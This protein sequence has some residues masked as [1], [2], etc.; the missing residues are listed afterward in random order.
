MVALYH[1][2]YSLN[3]CSTNDQGKGKKEEN[4]HGTSLNLVC[5]GLLAIGHGPVFGIIVLFLTDLFGVHR[6]PPG[7]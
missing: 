6:D 7:V 5:L 2:D 1:G 4:I 3:E